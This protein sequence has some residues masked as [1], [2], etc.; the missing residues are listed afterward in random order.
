MSMAARRAV[1][2]WHGK[3]LRRAVGFAPASC[4]G[5][6]VRGGVLGA[7]SRCAVEKMK[8]GCCAKSNRVGTLCPYLWARR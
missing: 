1:M 8:W 3:R 7:S 4:G 2:P 6:A 5:I